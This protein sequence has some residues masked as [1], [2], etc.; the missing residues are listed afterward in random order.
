MGKLN[1]AHHKSYHPYRLDNIERVK[2]DEE[3]ARQKEDREEGRMRLADSEARL[4]LLRGRSGS[5]KLKRKDEDEIPEPQPVPVLQSIS[6]SSGH[7]NL[8]ADIEQQ[9]M[10]AALT[11]SRELAR[12]N[13][14]P[15]E[16]KG[17]RLAP[18]EKELN[19]WYSGKGSKV[20]DLP[21]EKRMKDLSWKAVADPLASINSQLSRTYASMPSSSAARRIQAPANTT[22]ARIQRESSERAR[23]ME[24]IRRKKREK[25]R[26]ALG[27]GNMT[28]STV[29]GNDNDTTTGYG[30]VYNPRETEEAHRRWDHGSARDR[31]SGGQRDRGRQWD[32]RDGQRHYRHR[33]R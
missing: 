28:P 10:S 9:T 25:E 11:R 26:E 33:S 22:E 29:S 17:V 23:A 7:I 8:F 20:E 32:N 18:T 6:T 4:D 16:E 19:P 21:E 15:E 30:D 24:L 5:K 12:K 14:K 3:E 31:T 1:I 27:L 2:R 13:T